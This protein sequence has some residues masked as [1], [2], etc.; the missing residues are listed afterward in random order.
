MNAF[1]SFLTVE[2][3]L[4]SSSSLSISPSTFPSSTSSSNASSRVDNFFPGLTFDDARDCCILEI[5]DFLN[6][7]K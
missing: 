5:Y 4:K 7:S 1:G 6:S 3:Y 2:K